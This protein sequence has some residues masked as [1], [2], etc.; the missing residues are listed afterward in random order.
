MQVSVD[1]GPPERHLHGTA[2]ASR[3]SAAIW[4][5]PRERTFR[6]TRR[7]LPHCYSDRLDDSDSH[8]QQAQRASDQHFRGRGKADERAKS[9]SR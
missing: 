6:P 1:R 7:A 3:P 4:A 5:A 8:D 9:I 2:H